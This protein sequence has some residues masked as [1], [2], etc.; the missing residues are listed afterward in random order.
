MRKRTRE[1]FRHAQG[2]IRSRY[3]NKTLSMVSPTLKGEL[4]GQMHHGWFEKVKFFQSAD[5]SE[6]QFFLTSLAMAL[7]MEMFAQVA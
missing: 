3:Y 5:K 2:V 7:H 4:I 1:Y 6:K